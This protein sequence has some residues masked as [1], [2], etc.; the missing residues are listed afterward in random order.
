MVVVVDWPR[1]LRSSLL[2]SG[3][4]VADRFREGIAR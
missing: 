4:S 3:C 2:G 1:L